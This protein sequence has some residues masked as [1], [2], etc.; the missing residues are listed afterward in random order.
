MTVDDKEMII[1]EVT[2][3]G[4]RAFWRGEPESACPYGLTKFMRRCAWLAG[5]RD[6]MR[7]EL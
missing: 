1:D 7:G 4:A 6:A 5:Y 2:L 3:E